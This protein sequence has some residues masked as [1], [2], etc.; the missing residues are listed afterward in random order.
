MQTSDINQSLNRLPNFLGTFPCDQIPKFKLNCSCVINTDP[1]SKPGR[2]WV[3]I[4]VQDGV[5][6]YFDSYGLPPLNQYFYQALKTAPGGW[7][8][9]HTTF[10]SMQGITCG[11]Y[12]ILY[13][14]LRQKGLS[15]C[16]ITQL[17][18]NVKPV[19]DLISKNLIKFI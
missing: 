18:T 6:E 15:I 5:A 10:Q 13:L 3:A 8:W 2:H 4:F 19:N 14:K 9:N 7:H 1:S 12:C 11:H 16:K 17:F